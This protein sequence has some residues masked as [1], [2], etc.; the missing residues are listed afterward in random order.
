MLAAAVVTVVGL[1][2]LGEPVEDYRP[3]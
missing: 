3:E 2:L 1:R